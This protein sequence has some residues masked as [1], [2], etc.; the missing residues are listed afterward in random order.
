M[1]IVKLIILIK[2][3]SRVI[4]LTKDNMEI[5]NLGII[6]IFRVRQMVD[7]NNYFE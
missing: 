1:D 6:F 2:V 7:N 4:A 3:R 5:Y